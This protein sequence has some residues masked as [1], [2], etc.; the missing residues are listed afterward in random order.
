MNR[1][2]LMIMSLAL[3]THTAQ[4]ETASISKLVHQLDAF[5]YGVQTHKEVRGES[6][7]EMVQDLVLRI[8]ENDESEVEFKNYPSVLP[9]PDEGNHLSGLAK[10]SDVVEL[11]V[12]NNEQLEDDEKTQ[13]KIWKTVRAL[14][15]AGAAFGYTG[16]GSSACG[17]TFPSA[18]I[19]DVKTGKIY[20]LLLAG[21][22][23]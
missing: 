11:I 15:A 3:M 23:C 12:S 17:V 6:A 1:F 21:G 8:K 20:E 13:D 18:L 9:Q 7:D 10:M 22:S 2:Y 4:A 14:K 16:D 5:V 19:I